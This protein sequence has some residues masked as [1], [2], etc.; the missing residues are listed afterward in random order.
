MNCD[1]CGASLPFGLPRRTGLC[2][3][4]R[5]ASAQVCECEH[6]RDEHEGWSGRCTDTGS[7]GRDGRCSCPGFIPR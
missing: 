5:Q 2:D 4:C 1:V 7:W 6:D 3:D